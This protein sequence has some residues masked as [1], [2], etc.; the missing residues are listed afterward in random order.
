M[1]KIIEAF[2]TKSKELYELEDCVS[3]NLKK[4][5]YKIPNFNVSELSDKYVITISPID[6]SDM[7]TLG[8][9][10]ILKRWIK[11]SGIKFSNLKCGKMQHPRLGNEMWCEVYK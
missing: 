10:S 7:K 8:S 2:E 11:A 4:V 5:L 3:S 6:N 1:R 9:A